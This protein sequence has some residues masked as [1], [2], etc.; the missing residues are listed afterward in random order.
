MLRPSTLMVLAANLLPLAGV[1][2]WGW[3]ATVLLMLYWLETAAVAFWTVI[4]I[5][6]MSDAAVADTKISF[7]GGRRASPI[8]TALFIAAHA[9]VFMAVHFLF[10]WELFAGEWP[11]RIHG[12]TDFVSQ[13]VIGTG[14]WIPLV[15]LFLVHGV[16]LL[17]DAGE[18][19][20]R[21]CFRLQAR[22]ADS[23]AN[24]M[25]VVGLYVRIFVM[26]STIL[27]GGWIALIVGTA[28]AL[29]VLVALKCAVDIGFRTLADRVQDAWVKA[30]AASEAATTGTT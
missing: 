1:L 20:L 13:M 9:G 30:Q 14:L 8:G 28:G 15:V 16:I 10:L 12:L 25:A 5:A 6:M 17:F 26:Q 24:R 7:R 19:T 29:A 23:S 18:P 3:D 27:L 11:Q 21:R 22:A 4:R 2:A